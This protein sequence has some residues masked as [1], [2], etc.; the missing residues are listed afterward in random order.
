MKKLEEIESQI[1]WLDATA[2][3]T[4]RTSDFSKLR[5][6]VQADIKLDNEFYAR[7]HTAYEED[8]EKQLRHRLRLLEEEPDRT[9][10]H[11]AAEQ[12]VVFVHGTHP[13]FDPSENSAIVDGLSWDQKARLAIGLEPTLSTSSVRV[14]Q[15]NF[16]NI[17]AGVGLIIG[18]GKIEYAHTSDADTVPTSLTEFEI[19]KPFTGGT[20]TVTERDI[21][22]LEYIS[23]VLEKGPRER[24]QMK[25]NEI[26]VSRPKAVGV[27][28]VADDIT[29]ETLRDAYTVPD[30]SEIESFSAEMDLPV[31]GF[32]DG[33]FYPA[34]FDT[35]TNAYVL[36][37]S[38]PSS[39]AQFE[40]L[41]VVAEEK[42]SAI[43]KNAK[44]R[45]DALFK[46]P[47][48]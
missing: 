3:D 13:S 5:E 39:S 4:I 22:T 28:F 8:R 24:Q 1:R 16:E 34:V 11:F 15:E 20:R 46:V 23:Y 45:Q 12:N 29:D 26:V 42:R 2:R 36:D 9:I 40:D 37:E 43:I 41:P 21:P 30:Y 10:E 35:D 18:K 17:F 32:K 25:H 6:K 7:E 48:D 38:H 19:R 33:S 27:Y 31:F 47:I 44:L 14:G